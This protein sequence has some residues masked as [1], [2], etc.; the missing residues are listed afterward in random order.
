M[1]GESHRLQHVAFGAA[2]F[3][4]EDAIDIFG[5]F[6]RRD[7]VRAR[8]DDVAARVTARFSVPAIPARQAERR[9]SAS[10]ALCG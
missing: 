3:P 1:H 9:A 6:A 10:A 4:V 7:V 5:Y 2:G 8:R